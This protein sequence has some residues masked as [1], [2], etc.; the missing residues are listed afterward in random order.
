MRSTPQP[1]VVG[2][3]E[4]PN[5]GSVGQITWKASLAWPP[6]RVGSVSGSIT[7]WNSTIDPGHPWVITSGLASG[8]GDR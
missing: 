1:V 8:C 4:N 2:L 6:C 3:P 5:P 7:L